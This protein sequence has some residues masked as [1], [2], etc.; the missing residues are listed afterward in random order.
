MVTNGEKLDKTKVS[1]EK[2]NLNDFYLKARM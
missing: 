1:L 2:G